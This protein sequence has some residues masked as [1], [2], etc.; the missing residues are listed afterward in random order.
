M[1]A[2]PSDAADEARKF[3]QILA[4]CGGV[5]GLLNKLSNGSPRQ[6]EVA[7]EMLMQLT[8]GGRAR[9]AKL[10]AAGAIVPLV[11]ALINRGLAE[12]LKQH[13]MCAPANLAD[14]GNQDCAAI[15]AAGLPRHPPPPATLPDAND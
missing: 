2:T 11:A 9:G 10:V 15:T 1:P 5:S 13:A 12:L 6:K 3:A 14:S 7:A 4:R 8:R